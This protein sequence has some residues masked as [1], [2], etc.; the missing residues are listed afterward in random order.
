LETGTGI[1]KENIS[2]KNVEFRDKNGDFDT[3][4]ADEY[5]RGLLEN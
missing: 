2:E 1:N 5:F 3:K 4:E